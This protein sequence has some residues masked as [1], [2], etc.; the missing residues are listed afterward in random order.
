MIAVM[1]GCEAH[2]SDVLHVSR[3]LEAF[4]YILL[5]VGPQS[6]FCPF[7]SPGR[8]AVYTLLPR[9]EIVDHVVVIV[10]S[11]RGSFRD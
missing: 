9:I 1:S 5:I 3:S 7:L 4:V 6:P 10:L 8:L 11:V 2:I